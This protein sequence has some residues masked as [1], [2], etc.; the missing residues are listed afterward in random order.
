MHVL[1]YTEACSVNPLKTTISQLLMNDSPTQQSK[2]SAIYLIFMD[3]LLQME[4]F[5]HT[6]STVTLHSIWT[7]RGNDCGIRWNHRVDFSHFCLQLVSKLY[8][9]RK[10]IRFIKIITVKCRPIFVI[11]Y[12][13]EHAE[14]VSCNMLL[15]AIFKCLRI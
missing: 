3:G 5:G 13:L 15:I 10:I 11:Y 2:N 14:H 8:R 1:P 6:W 12:T 9:R 7:L 4:D